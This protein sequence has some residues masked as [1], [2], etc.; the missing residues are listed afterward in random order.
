MFSA[1]WPSENGGREAVAY[2]VKAVFQT[3]SS[4]AIFAE[5][6]FWHEGCKVAADAFFGKQA[7]AITEI[8]TGR[9]VRQRPLRQ[10]GSGS[11]QAG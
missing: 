4:A 3:A 1:V 6:D 8:E 10:C 11:K 9:R 2:R 7:F 5:S